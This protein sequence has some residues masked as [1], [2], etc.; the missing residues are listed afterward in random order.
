LV[1]P[2]SDIG[3]DHIKQAVETF[4]K[5]NPGYTVEIKGGYG[6]PT[7]PE[8]QTPPATEGAAQ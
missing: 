1:V 3:K 5:E 6:N 4:Q 2:D 8:A 7:P